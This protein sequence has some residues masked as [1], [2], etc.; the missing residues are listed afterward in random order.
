VSDPIRWSILAEVGK[1]DELPGV[2][3]ESMLPARRPT[4]SYHMKLLLD[5]GLIRRR[6]PGRNFY[7]SL[8]RDVFADLLDVL[9]ELA[10]TPPPGTAS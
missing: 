4:I 10:P 6:R 8:R 7:Y 5:A 1:V 2:M 9:R 3:L